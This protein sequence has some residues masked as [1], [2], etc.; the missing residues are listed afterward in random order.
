V[1]ALVDSKKTLLD[2]TPELLAKAAQE[3]AGLTLTVKNADIVSCTNPR[4][5]VETYKVQGG[6]SPTE[7][8]RGLSVRQKGMQQNRKII[9]KLAEQQVKAELAL[10]EKVEAYSNSNSQQ[11][12][13]L[14]KLN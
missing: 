13:R 8:R 12:V 4:K 1:K 5:L 11:S 14:K 6:P 7:V 3:S 9:A 2:A 10:K